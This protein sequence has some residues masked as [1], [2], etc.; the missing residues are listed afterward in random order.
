M[1]KFIALVLVVL[2]FPSTVVASPDGASLL[3]ACNAA[4]KQEDGVKVSDKESIEALWCTGYVAGYLDG[5][6]V[7]SATSAKVC[8]PSEGISGEQAI[9]VAVKWL[10]NHPEK[11]HESGRVEMLLALANAF[12]CK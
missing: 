4:I 1:R 2:S 5:L 6:K 9:R 12:P 11:L 3:R 10:K 7:S 8:F